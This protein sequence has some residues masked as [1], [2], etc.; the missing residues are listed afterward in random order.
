MRALVLTF[1]ALLVLTFGSWAL[2]SVSLGAIELPIALGIAT[3][4]ATLVVIFFMHVLDEE[5]STVLALGSGVF[6]V[7]LLVS[8]VAVEVAT[9]G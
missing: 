5:L 8:F 1:V 2:A 6:F 4:K 3:A 9:R 7:L